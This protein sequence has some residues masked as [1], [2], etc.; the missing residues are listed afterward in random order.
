MG[1][2][3]QEGCSQEEEAWSILRS[4]GQQHELPGGDV[5]PQGLRGNQPRAL[6]DSDSDPLSLRVRGSGRLASL[7][8]LKMSGCAFKNLKFTPL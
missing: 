3:F 1:F 8:V 4:R 7:L 2:P 6:R 5:V